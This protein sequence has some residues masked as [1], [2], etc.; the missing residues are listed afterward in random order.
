MITDLPDRQFKLSRQ[1]RPPL[2]SARAAL[3]SPETTPAALFWIILNYWTIKGLACAI[4][5][6]AIDHTASP[7]RANFG[8]FQ[9][10]AQ[11]GTRHIILCSV[12]VLQK[13]TATFPPNFAHHSTKPA[14]INVD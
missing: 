4:V 2:F 8:D 1:R 7:S 5:S 14:P 6:L 11:N 12:K 3:G 9:K 10:I 13:P